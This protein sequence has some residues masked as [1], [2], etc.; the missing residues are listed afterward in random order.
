[1]QKE[2]IVAYAQL[3]IELEK[4]VFSNPVAIEKLQSV[5]HDAALDGYSD[6]FEIFISEEK[7]VIGVS[8]PVS[9]RIGTVLEAG[10][11]LGYCLRSFEESDISGGSIWMS[12]V[13]PSGEI[14]HSPI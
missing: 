12:L 1:M 8:V 14:I 7:G 6:D 11:I 5:L 3:N 13:T 2:P 9:E 4:S 10:G